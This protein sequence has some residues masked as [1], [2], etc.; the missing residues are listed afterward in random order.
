MLRYRFFT[1]LLMLT[2]LIFAQ[3]Y[4]QQKADYQMDIDVDA[5]KY[6][7]NGK[8]ELRYTNNSPEVLDKVYFHLFFNAFQPNSAMDHRLK[9][10]KDPDPRMVTNIGTQDKPKLQSKIEVLKPD[11]IG[12]Q[13]IKS[14]TQN[15][16]KVDF[17]ISGTIM[18]VQLAQAIQSNSTTTFQLEWEAQVPLQIRRSGRQSAEGIELSMTQWYPKIAAYD[19]EGWHT[20]EYI[21]R[22]FYAPFGDY[23]V[24]INID[25]AYIIGA[26][27]KLQNPCDVTGYAIDCKNQSNQKTNSIKN[28]WHFKANNIHDFAWAADPDYTVTKQQVPN[29]PALYFVCQKTNQNQ[30]AWEDVQQPS[31]DFF[32]YMK[33][34]FGAYPWSTYTIVQGGDGGMEYGTVTLITGNREYNSLKGVIFHEAAHSWFQHLFGF[35]ETVHEWMDEGFTSYA[36]ACA[37]HFFDKKTDTNPVKSSYRT[38]ASLAKSEYEEPLTTLADYY[39]YNQVYGIQAYVKGSI[40][41]E[42][43]GYVIGNENKQKTFLRFYDEWKFKHPTPNDFKRVAEKVSGIELKWLFA[44]FV[45]TTRTVDYAINGIENNTVSIQ[46]L[47]DFPMPL[48]VV[49]EYQDGTKELFYIPL[50]AM[51]ANKP[52][53]DISEYKGIKRTVLDAWAWTNPDYTIQTNKSIKSAQI[54]PSQRLQD[55]DL[56]NNQYPKTESN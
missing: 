14:I 19:T 52:T 25:K 8:M 30:Q 10:I 17:T 3:N 6:Q 13:R 22:E 51:R 7:Y 39:N 46:N 43:L 38:Y 27:G 26:S 5:K 32:L 23:D 44:N 29:G 15:G 54:D 42:V 50:L 12:F 55:V 33:E 16:K 53:E 48:D 11:E 35:N 47:S 36:D 31:V 20:D 9:S 24:K 37:E 41:P 28:Q 40:F 49:L 18:K 2:S 1:S 4:W 56:T 34:H 45:G 21:A